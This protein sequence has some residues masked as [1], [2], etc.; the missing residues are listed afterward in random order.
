MSGRGQKLIHNAS[1]KEIHQ[2]NRSAKIVK[3]PNTL[4][5][6]LKRAN[7]VVVIDDC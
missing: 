6:D 5:D 2:T 3:R 7:P 4:A 1:F